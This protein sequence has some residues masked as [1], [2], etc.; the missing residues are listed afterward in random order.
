MPPCLPGAQPPP[1]HRR[2]RPLLFVAPNQL[3]GHVPGPRGRYDRRGASSPWRGVRGKQNDRK[4][5][6]DRAACRIRMAGKRQAAS[7]RASHTDA[8]S[9]N[10][11]DVPAGRVAYR[12][13]MARIMRQY[14]PETRPAAMRGAAEE[15]IRHSLPPGFRGRWPP[16]QRPERFARAGRRR[17]WLRRRR[18]CDGW[19]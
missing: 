5:R 10:V 1:G 15:F 14:R 8:T 12:A 7:A 11:L 19:W 13:H 18:R 2:R 16:S 4:R 17:S 6:R 9:A 3:A